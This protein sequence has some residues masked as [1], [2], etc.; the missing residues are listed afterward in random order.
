MQRIIG[1]TNGQEYIGTFCTISVGGS[2]IWVQFLKICYKHK[3]PRR[4]I[5]QSEM[6]S[7]YY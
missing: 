2:L 5:R 1:D 7:E 6:I 4:K 3:G